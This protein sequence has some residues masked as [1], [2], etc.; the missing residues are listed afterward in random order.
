MEPPEFE[1]RCGLPLDIAWVGSDCS[2]Q[3]LGRIEDRQKFKQS[4]FVG[5]AYRVVDAKG[6][7][8]AHV[9]IPQGRARFQ[10][11]CEHFD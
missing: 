11:S 5:Y 2:L 7:V 8:A 3:G 1:N 4:S 6:R 9:V 10:L